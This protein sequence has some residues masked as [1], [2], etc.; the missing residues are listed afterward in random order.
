[1]LRTIAPLK[2]NVSQKKKKFKITIHGIANYDVANP[3]ANAQEFVDAVNEVMAKFYVEWE[4]KFNND[5]K[6][7]TN[8]SFSNCDVLGHSNKEYP[9]EI[10]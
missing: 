10:Y 3:E 9:D 6:F 8:S 2:L 1:M 7:K 4:L 5:T